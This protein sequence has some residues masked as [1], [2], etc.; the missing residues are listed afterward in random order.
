MTSPFT[1]AEQQCQLV[2]KAIDECGDQVLL[3]VERY[4]RSDDR[5]RLM[6]VAQ[7]R[8]ARAAASVNALASVVDEARSL[9]RHLVVA[10]PEE[11]S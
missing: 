9:S 7:E 3:L 11:E 1:D 10:D 5:L 8:V 6:A 4:V 2:E